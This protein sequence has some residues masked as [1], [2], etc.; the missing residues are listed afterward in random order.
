MT[1]HRRSLALFLLLLLLGCERTPSADQVSADISARISQAFGNTLELVDIR[2]RGTAKDISAPAEESRRI[3][4]FDLSLRARE[5]LDL[6]AWDTPGAASLVS[7]LGCGPKGIY[8]VR[9][10]G[11]KA[12][13]VIRAHGSAIYRREAN[14]WRPVAAAGFT[15][16]PAPVT[17]NQAPRPP[18]ENLLA[19]LQGTIRSVPPGIAPRS[20]I[21]IA[22]ELARAIN[23]IHARLDHEQ[24]GYAIAAGP[25]QGQYVRLAGAL[26]M[27]G[28]ERKV[29]ITPLVTAG[30]D[31]NVRLLRDGR[32]LL[33]IVQGDIAALAFNGDEPFADL[34]PSSMLRALGSLYIE[35]LHVIVRA[36]SPVQTVADLRGRRVNVGPVGSG[37]RVTALRILAAHD[38]LPEQATMTELTLSPALAALR[39]G[40]IDAILQVIGV[41]ANEIRNAFA[42]LP[43]R[44]VPLDD[45]TIGR[46]THADPAI[47]AAPVPPGAYAGVQKPVPTI[48]VAAVLVT[49]TNLTEAEGDAATRLVF[50]ATDL[51]SRGSP[52]GAQVSPR[53]ART[54]LT[55]PMHEGAEH[56]LAGLASR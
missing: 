29:R 18:V 44:L 7:M 54:G 20:N 9:S 4:Y 42:T 38:V 55:I 17:D 35:P 45:G 14:G 1:V 5:D 15:P 21:I 36:D 32:V 30:S 43:L 12:G 40:R 27:L 23:N 3:V 33:G 24:A 41:P 51:V 28:A 49:T 25:E 34:G 37:S 48:G 50:A 31:E 53:T 22:D 56:A 26:A 16:S 13:D 8:G 46:L 6:G 19:A 52:Q 47:V 2:R 39:D 11:N 10:G